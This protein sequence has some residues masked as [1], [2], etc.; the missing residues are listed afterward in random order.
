MALI[1]ESLKLQSQTQLEVVLFIGLFVRL[2]FKKF[3]FLE[4]QLSLPFTG[5]VLMPFHNFGREKAT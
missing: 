1:G 4:I 5:N 3:Y 2:T